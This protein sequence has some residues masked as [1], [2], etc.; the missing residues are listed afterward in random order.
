L[1]QILRR[2]Q[3]LSSELLVVKLGGSVLRDGA[4]IRNA[5][6]QLKQETDKG[7]RV[8]AVVSAIKGMTDTLLSISDAISPDIPASV[9]DEIIRLG[10]EQSARLLTATLRLI[11]VDAVEITP[12]SPSWPIITNEIYGD[13]EPLMD[14]C[15]DAVRLGIKPLVERGRLPVIC[16]FIGRSLSG[17]IT[18]LGRGG[19]DTTATII[20]DCLDADQL[21]LIK[22]VGGVYSADPKQVEDAGFIESM[23]AEE[24]S[25]MTASG[26]RVLQDKVF[27]YKPA[28]LDIRIVSENGPLSA[29]GT[30][31]TGSAIDLTY[32][33]Y[34]KPVIKLT[35]VGQDC[36][37]T[38]LLTGLSQMFE[39]IG[40]NIYSSTGFEKS[41]SLI[42]DGDHANIL[43]K[44]HDLL[45]K[46]QTTAIT[47][48]E[49]LALFRVHGALLKSNRDDIVELF[50]GLDYKHLESNDTMIEIVVPWDEKEKTEQLLS[51]EIHLIIEK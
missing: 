50:S 24:A 40:A 23:G 14:H 2:T 19:T 48:Q 13:A 31:I 47:S 26:S 51:K 17:N 33:L 42:V 39:D 6:E 12:E 35:I 38:G 30:V 21:I 27:K 10:E 41:I 36:F 11:G 32:S 34:K 8:V 29:G 20:A 16:G 46:F 1:N 43:N 7:N 9:V 4:A 18:T 45:K 49:N 44:V 22:D 28:E 5:A 25:V 15:R 37:E 3:K